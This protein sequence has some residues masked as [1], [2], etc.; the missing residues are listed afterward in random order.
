MGRRKEQDDKHGTAAPE[1][2]V[3]VD[4]VV[5][6]AVETAVEAIADVALTDLLAAELSKARVNGDH[7]AIAA[8]E[9]LYVHAGE[10]LV[11]LRAA[12]SR[13]QG[14]VLDAVRRLKELL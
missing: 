13:V 2:S 11:H 14:D 9:M 1:V 6:T 8:L 7:T 12:E 5:D 10:F 3:P 4:D